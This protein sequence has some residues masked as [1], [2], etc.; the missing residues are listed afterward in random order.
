MWG[1]SQ[2]GTMRGSSRVS[3]MGPNAKAPRKP[4]PRTPTDDIVATEAGP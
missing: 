2:V 4:A 3:E 1:S